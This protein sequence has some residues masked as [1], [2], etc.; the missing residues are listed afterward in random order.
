MDHGTYYIL[1]TGKFVW[2]S[3]L[4]AVKF[5]LSIHIA[6][7]LIRTDFINDLESE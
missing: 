4:A 1:L 2:E 5:L 3:V 6:D 7:R